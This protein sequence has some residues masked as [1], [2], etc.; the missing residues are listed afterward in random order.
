MVWELLFFLRVILNLIQ[1][2]SSIVLTESWVIEFI[3][4]HSTV[5][6]AWIQIGISILIGLFYCFWINNLCLALRNV[7]RRT[8][9]KPITL[10][11]ITFSIE[12][13]IYCFKMQTSSNQS[14]FFNWS[15]LTLFPKLLLLNWKT[16]ERSFRRLLE[17]WLWAFQYR[18]FIFVIVVWRCVVLTL[19]SWTSVV[20][21]WCVFM[22]GWT[23]V[24]IS[25]ISV[26]FRQAFA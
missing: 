9:F 3:Y 20:Q 14:L 6:L 7:L 24:V 1:L 16:F 19:L 11:S 5:V 13:I 17:R 21:K 26:V 25:K 22:K 4:S 2:W 23:Y 15:H 8:D 18:W 12:D 10:P